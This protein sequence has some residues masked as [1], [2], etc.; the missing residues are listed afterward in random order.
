MGAFT[1]LTHRSTVSRLPARPDDDRRLP[2]AAT[3][4]IG[5]LAVFGAITLVQWLLGAVLGLVRFGIAIVVVLAVLAWLFG[6]RADR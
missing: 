2:V 5:G 1:P 4:A 3:V 6:R